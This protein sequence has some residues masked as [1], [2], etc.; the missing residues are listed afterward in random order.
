MDGSK[1]AAGRYASVITSVFFFRDDQGMAKKRWD[2][3]KRTQNT[4][5][6]SAQQE[7]P[8]DMGKLI[9][10]FKWFPALALLINGLLAGTGY[11]FITGFLAKVGIDVAELEISLPS[12]LLY[13]YIFT[14][15]AL[16]ESARP[17]LLAVTGG[18]AAL[19][20]WFFYTAFKGAYP[21]QND[22]IRKTI[23][24]TLGA[25]SAVLLLIGPAWIFNAGGAKAMRSEL[26]KID[27]STT[28]GQLTRTHS[29]NTPDGPIEG[30]LVIADQRYT[31]IRAGNA[32][33]KIA[34]DSQKVVRAITFTS[35]ASNKPEEQDG[36]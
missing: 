26:T 29:I 25:I 30:S 35:D 14:L 17:V 36:Q 34:N 8:L 19:F 2:I 23:S 10:Q 9:D 15:D 28:L 13:G 4:P 24:A 32:V 21:K 6:A 18:L 1:A 11:L 5:Q 12:L 33:Y 3:P 7:A 31:Y 22:W 20:T 27:I 16:S